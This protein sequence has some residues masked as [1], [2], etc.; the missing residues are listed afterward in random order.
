MLEKPG[1]Q[2]VMHPLI[3]PEEEIVGRTVELAM[4]GEVSSLLEKGRPQALHFTGPAGIGKTELLR[5]AAARLNRPE[6][7]L[8]TVFLS[9]PGLG[10]RGSFLYLARNLFTSVRSFSVR[11]ATYRILDDL[12]EEWLKKDKD[13]PGRLL[14]QLA[15]RAGEAEGGCLLVL[16]SKLAAALTEETGCRL[17]VFVD[18][19]DRFPGV[20]E[21]LE[22]SLSDDWNAGNRVSW[23]MA[24]RTRKRFMADGLEGSF[25]KEVNLKSLDDEEG[26][27][28]LVLA[29]QKSG[30]ALSGECRE[31]ASL[32]SGNPS[33]IWEFASSSRLAGLTELPDL[34]TFVRFYAR[35]LAEGYLHDY[36][37]GQ[38]LGSEK[39]LNDSRDLLEVMLHLIGGE[40]SAIDRKGLAR[41]MLRE[42]ES[43][44]G[45]LEALARRGL[46]EE[47]YD[48]IKVS[49]PE[50]M[51]DFCRDQS[52]RHLEGCSGPEAEAR[53]VKD[54]KDDLDKGRQ[55]Q[56]FR[57]N[58]EELETYIRSW[59]DQVLPRSL[60]D[61]RKFLEIIGG[62]SGTETENLLKK[63]DKSRLVL[64][65]VIDVWPERF[66]GNDQLPPYSIDL[67]A[68]V[69]S[70]GK[71]NM[72]WLALEIGLDERE[73]TSAMVEEFS[74]RCRLFENR[75][76]L[77][78]GELSLWMISGGSFS[79]EAQEIISRLRIWSS[80]PVQI[81]LMTRLS[82]YSKT[83]QLRLPEGRS[84][85]EEPSVFQM[86]IPVRTETELV[87]AR[88]LEQLGESLHLGEKDLGQ[89]KMALVEAC[90]NAFE[91]GQ[92]EVKKV[93]LTF[94]VL[95]GVL[96]IEVF[97][98]G[99]PFIPARIVKPSIEQKMGDV[100]KRG[101]GLS[102]IQAL[103]DE[104]EFIPK[105]EGTV[106]KM[107]KYY[108]V[109]P[110]ED[111]SD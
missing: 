7:R 80:S 34:D 37:L 65:E 63:K 32:L 22:Y 71:G 53:L 50:T 75:L 21:F 42:G 100:R 29:M 107:I 103:M 51:V 24:S 16:L 17:M 38:L 60:F 74:S 67:L 86:V 8:A 9:W 10:L 72:R 99:R 6:D 101:W 73:V 64:P 85:E 41:E 98:R 68:S 18:D 43:L 26:R 84:L 23:I 14:G 19:L 54:K 13:I 59:K 48:R 46:V 106:I 35:E 109:T 97:N 90:L 81:R 25:L 1:N 3:R 28:L 94:R 11:S 76:G 31:G 96:E 69:A 27:E 40:G 5:Q 20:G 15:G 87:A 77:K 88:A 102:I 44:T 82:G 70:A 2:K 45:S 61:Y 30:V 91:H 33:L 36:H 93:Y 47:R 57:R 58:V 110:G 78:T 108:S 4:I 89:I 12:D 104:V 105:E 39:K 55:A 111:A 56:V 62:A 79:S 83:V 95:P 49:I 52:R 66:Q 92:S